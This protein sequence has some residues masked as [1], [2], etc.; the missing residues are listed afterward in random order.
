MCSRASYNKPR[1]APTRVSRDPTPPPPISTTPVPAPP[2]LHGASRSACAARCAARCAE[3]VRKAASAE[4][5]VTSP[6]G[7][8]TPENVPPA[9]PAL[10]AIPAARELLLWSKA[11]AAAAQAVA[12]ALSWRFPE[13]WPLPGKGYGSAASGAKGPSRSGDVDGDDVSSAA[14]AA[15]CR[16]PSNALRPRRASS[17]FSW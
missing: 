14:A 4:A 12:S 9:L 1:Q 15:A 5:P 7:S 6:A 8:L 3:A 10:P 11:A 16:E 2:A 13:R 17:P